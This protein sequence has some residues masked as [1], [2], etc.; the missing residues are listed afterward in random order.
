MRDI[1]WKVRKYWTFV[2]T[3]NLVIDNFIVGND[4]FIIDMQCLAARHAIIYNLPFLNTVDR[5]ICKSMLLKFCI[6]TALFFH[7][8][9]YQHLVTN[10]FARMFWNNKHLRNARTEY[11]EGSSTIKMFEI[12]ATTTCIYNEFAIALWHF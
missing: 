7:F 8:F 10:M 3:V 5:N 2:N 11:Y 12:W 9:H 4:K 1:L 6:F